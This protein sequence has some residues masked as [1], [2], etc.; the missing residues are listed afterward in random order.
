[1]ARRPSRGTP[2]SRKRTP[3]RRRAAPRR[4]WPLLLVL[5]LASLLPLGGWLY[6]LDQRVS[7]HF[8]GARWAVPARVYARALELYP[9][10][11]LGADRFEAELR[12][13]GYRQAQAS[14]ATPG[15][16]ARDG[17]RFSVVTRSFPFWDGEEPS[18]ALWLEF[19]GQR[20]IELRQRDTGARIALARLE[21]VEIAAI[22]PAHH[23]DRILLR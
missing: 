23:E 4:W 12:R 9:G 6:G 2:T 20:L 19:S 11:T 3:R 14:G 7:S 21:P 13:L 18:R 16:F 10:V 22:Y 1:M 17:E 15:Y 8:E 5:L